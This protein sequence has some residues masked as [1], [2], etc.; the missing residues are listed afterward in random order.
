MAFLSFLTGKTKPPAYDEA[1]AETR[2]EA[3]RAV[4]PPGA[5]V[6]LIPPSK[7]MALTYLIDTVTDRATTSRILTSVV[8]IVSTG[9]ERWSVNLAVRDVEAESSTYSSV[10]LPSSRLALLDVVVRAHDELYAHIPTQ[11]IALDA[12]DGTFTVTD[13]PPGR[14]LATAR[15]AVDW[16]QR[17]LVEAVPPW[18]DSSLSVDIGGDGVN[19]DVV[20]SATIEREPDPQNH[21]R[22]SDEEWVARVFAAW[23]DNLPVLEAMLRLPVPAGHSVDLGFSDAKLRPRLTVTQHETYDEDEDAAKELV[24]TIRQ[25]VPDTKLKV[26]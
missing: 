3:L 7:G 17:V 25:H 14:A 2:V 20:Y 1:A 19:C 16:W 23:T 4:L 6:A 10:D 5:E 12:S 15:V 26:G 18:Y 9:T 11:T 13:V 21:S 24:A 8:E 22:V